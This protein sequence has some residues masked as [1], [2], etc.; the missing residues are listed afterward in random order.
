LYGLAR[1]QEAV[2]SYEEGLKLEPTNAQLKK[3]LEDAKDQLSAG[4][5]GDMGTYQ[6]IVNYS[7]VWMIW[8]GSFF[9]TL[10]SFLL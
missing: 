3:G 10:D 8:C 1:F 2:E 7:V 4:A 5:A 9:L 6:R